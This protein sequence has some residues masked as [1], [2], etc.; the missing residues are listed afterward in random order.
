MYSRHNVLRYVQTEPE[1]SDDFTEYL[2]SQYDGKR[3]DM[4]HLT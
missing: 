1:T 3:E 2:T 4:I